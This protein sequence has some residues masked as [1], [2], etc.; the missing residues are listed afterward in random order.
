MKKLLIF[1]TLATI[2]LSSFGKKF[3]N[4]TYFRFGYSL[5][6]W[7]QFGLSKEAWTN[8]IEKIGATFETGNIFMINSV[9][10][11]E[12]MALGINVDYLYIN[13]FLY[14]DDDVNVG[15]ARVGSKIGPSFTYSPVKKLAFD[16]FTKADFAWAT[17]VVPYQGNIN[18]AEDHYTSNVDVGFSTGLNI[19]YGIL[20]LGIEYNTI[21]PKLSSDEYEGIY[22]QDVI[23]S[24]ITETNSDEKSKLSSINF[25]IGLSF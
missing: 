12:N 25:T 8:N 24:Y 22:L 13:S 20:M 11:P 5:P 9:P 16:I 23:N 10:S 18:D 1:F 6:S 15:G 21:S 4:E 2:S 14:N 17:V 7:N 3:D 19:R